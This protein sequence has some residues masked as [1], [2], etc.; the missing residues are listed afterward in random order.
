[1]DKQKT[2]LLEAYVKKIIALGKLGIIEVH[3][4]KKEAQLPYTLEEINEL[5]T[6]VGKFVDYTDSKV[7]NCLTD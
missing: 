2:T 6:E 7:T 4:N 3:Q 5:Y 1:M